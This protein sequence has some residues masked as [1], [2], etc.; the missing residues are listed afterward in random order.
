MITYEDF[1]K[2]ELR[3]ARI[4]EAEKVEGADSPDGP[5]ILTPEKEVEPDAIIK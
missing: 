4:V 3:V 2:V 5:V 1:K